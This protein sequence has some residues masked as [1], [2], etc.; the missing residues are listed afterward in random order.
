M[1]KAE[2]YLEYLSAEGYRPELDGDGDVRFRKE[3][4]TYYITVDEKDE[5]YFRLMYPNFW[6]LES[7]AERAKALEVMGE[8]NATLK[9]VKVFP[10]RD[11]TDVTATVELFLEPHEGFK[12][13]FER[14]VRL[15]QDALGR[16]RRGMLD[17]N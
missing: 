11:G 1:T 8:V 4:G 10:V 2:M 7:P 3:G 15:I 12:V 16:F 6:L 17:V 9:V 14:C 5:R 13:V